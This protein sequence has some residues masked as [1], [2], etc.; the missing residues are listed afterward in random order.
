MFHRF[1]RIPKRLWRE[2]RRMAL[3]LVLLFVAGY[4]REFG[5]DRF[6]Q[7]IPSSLI[8]GLI[9][10]LGFGLIGLFV[11]LVIPSTRALFEIIALG[12]VLLSLLDLS[13]PMIRDLEGGKILFSILLMNGLL[14][15]LYGTWSHHRFVTTKAV[16][17]AQ[18]YSPLSVGTLWR[19]LIALPENFDHHI[20]PNL[21]SITQLDPNNIEIV[22]RLD[23]IGTTTERHE[24]LSY[25]AG[26]SI[27]FRYSTLDAAPDTLGTIGIVEY[28]ITNQGDRRCFEYSIHPDQ[29][30]AIHRPTVWLDDGTARMIDARIEE[31]EDHHAKA[32]SKATQYRPAPA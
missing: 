30:P 1:K 32:P 16:Q 24:I 12:L 8:L 19:G 20:N 26:V 21:I 17:R 2:R 31:I 4:L 14:M 18:C 11:I 25:E 6:F 5:A 3:V 9:Y 10:A 29:L 23:P 28:R 15:V 13:V 7:G 22:E 27:R